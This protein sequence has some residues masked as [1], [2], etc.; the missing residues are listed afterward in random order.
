ME[1]IDKN[2]A[3][4]VA[5]MIHDFVDPEGAL[6]VPNALNIVE[7]IA[8]LIGE[9]RAAGAPVIYLNDA[10]LHDDLEFE[11]WPKHAIAGTR[12]AEVIK[13]LEPSDN[14]IIVE[15][16]RYS[17]FYKT[18]LESTLEEKGI[19]R[20]VIT[21]AVTNICVLT[22]AYDA[23]MRN[24]EVVVFR[25]AVAALDEKDGEFALAQIE[26]VMGGTVI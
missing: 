25:N 9:A 20:V 11:Q 8:E 2:T 15:K 12:G 22:T 6:H 26:K 23:V 21:G 18:D 7:N 5:D 3:L 19:R 10:H 16:T 14:D 1:L 24:Y 17:G 13:E 4:L